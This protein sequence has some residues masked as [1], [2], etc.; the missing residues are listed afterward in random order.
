MIYNDFYVIDDDAR[1]INIERDEGFDSTSEENSDLENNE[2]RD[3][4]NE[5]ALNIEND[6]ESASNSD[7][8]SEQWITGDT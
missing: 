8:G 1:Y 3:N 7:S 6:N 2:M 4:I 5:N